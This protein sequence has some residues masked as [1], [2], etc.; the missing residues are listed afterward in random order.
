MNARRITAEPAMDTAGSSAPVDFTGQ[1]L[2]FDNGAPVPL[3]R[4]RSSLHWLHEHMPHLPPPHPEDLVRHYAY[5][6][7]ALLSREMDRL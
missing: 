7:E 5:F 4:T 1:R 3:P 2:I 6:E